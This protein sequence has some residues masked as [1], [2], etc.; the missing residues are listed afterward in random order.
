MSDFD[1][2]LLILQ[3][4]FGASWTIIASTFLNEY[5]KGFYEVILRRHIAEISLFVAFILILLEV[6]SN[7]F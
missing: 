7:Y 3:E 1:L 5:Q 6:C 4:K 2:S